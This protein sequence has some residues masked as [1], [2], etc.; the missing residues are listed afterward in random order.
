MCF[1]RSGE[2]GGASDDARSQGRTAAA[3]LS[4]RPTG[5]GRVACGDGSAA[6]SWPTTRVPPRPPLPGAAAIDASVAE[7][8]EAFGRAIALANT[9]AEAA[10]VR[11]HLDRLADG[12]RLTRSQAGKPDVLRFHGGGGGP[13]RYR[14]ADLSGVNGMLSR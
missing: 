13:G 5:S 1:C 2:A 3:A 7:A 8:R 10:H 12:E 9:P 14:T 11:A 4:D 6:G